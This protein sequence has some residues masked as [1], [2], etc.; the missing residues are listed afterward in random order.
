[1]DK[2]I[3]VGTNNFVT[4]TGIFAAT[5]HSLVHNNNLYNRNAPVFVEWVAVC[6]AR[7]S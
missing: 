2:Y 4:S 7:S 3:R 6:E 1:M 5:I